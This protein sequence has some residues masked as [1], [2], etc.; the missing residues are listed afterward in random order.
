MSNP[1]LNNTTLTNI[2]PPADRNMFAR[3]PRVRNLNLSILPTVLGLNP[4]A[5]EQDPRL[6]PA[7]EKLQ[8]Y[9]YRARLLAA[10][11]EYIAPMF[12]DT[13]PSSRPLDFYHA[14]FAATHPEL[15]QHFPVKL[16]IPLSRSAQAVIAE[17]CEHY[18]K[19]WYNGRKILRELH[20]DIET[21]AKA[22]FQLDSRLVNEAFSSDEWVY[23]GWQAGDGPPTNYDDIA[24]ELDGSSGSTIVPCEFPN[25]EPECSMCFE[26]LDNSEKYRAVSTECQH[27]FGAHCLRTWI[28]ENFKTT[29]PL[30]P[31]C[32]R[33][34]FHVQPGREMQ[35][36]LANMTWAELEQLLAG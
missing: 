27:I 31:K 18:E 10:V 25:D 33:P 19:H 6:L 8:E 2:M 28:V 16:M 34:L 5:P 35:C 13:D 7:A 12:E 23:C 32:R 14:I 30:C 17:L 29:I 22:N 9:R 26:N 3:T 4:N 36:K 24:R 15:V 20:K 11:F 21:V 1:S